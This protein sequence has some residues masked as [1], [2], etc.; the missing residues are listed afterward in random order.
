MPRKEIDRLIEDLQSTPEEYKI[1]VDKAQQAK[2]ALYRS[3][4][5]SVSSVWS[6]VPSLTPEWLWNLARKGVGEGV[7][8]NWSM[9]FVNDALVILGSDVRFDVNKRPSSQLVF[10]RSILS[11]YADDEKLIKWS[12][13]A[14]YRTQL[15]TNAL[16]DGASS[17][18]GAA[19]EAFFEERLSTFQK[20]FA[21]ITVAK[22]DESLSQVESYEEPMYEDRERNLWD[23]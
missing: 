22:W 14:P 13:S 18:L 1:L 5:A 19:R 11:S 7:L 15:V 8:D 16:N 2:R 3:E 12:N 21:A 17:I 4:G 6:L 9:E 10:Y 23:N 20:V